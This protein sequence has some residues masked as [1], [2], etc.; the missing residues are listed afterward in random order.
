MRNYFTFGG[1]DSRDFGIYISGQGTFNAPERAYEPIAI[2]G[3]NGD[4]L[5]IDRR[6]ENVELIYPA[7]VYRTF[8]A[9]IAAMRDAF[10]ALTG[11][12]ELTDSYHP[13]EYRLAYFPGGTEINATT[14]NDAGDFELTFICKP[15]RFLTSGK[16]EVD[17]VAAGGTITNPTAQKAQ[18]LIHVTGYGN[19]FIG[20]QRVTIENVLPDVYIDCEMMDCYNGTTNANDY[21]SF[22]NVDFPTLPTGVTGFSM[23]DTITD[24]TIVP[25]WWRA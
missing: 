23:S 17:I 21:V 5:G 22:G 16:T 13:D 20:T 14:K 15:Q 8:S 1:L 3:R 4:L 11:Y 12:Q 25:R 2:P 24:L 19:L 18:P 6:M 7:F 10:L 9:N